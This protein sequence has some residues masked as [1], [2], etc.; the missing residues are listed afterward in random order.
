MDIKQKVLNAMK[1]SGEPLKSGDIAK[2]IEVDSKE[3]SKAIKE[4]KKEGAIESP[5]R[6]YYK[7]C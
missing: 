6:C 2:I 7:A 4:L 5:K 3:V 1:Q